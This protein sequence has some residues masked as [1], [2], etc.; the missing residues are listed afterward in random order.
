MHFVLSV[1][2]PALPS[3]TSTHR[4]VIQ[5]V[6]DVIMGLN[7]WVVMDQDYPK[8]SVLG[9]AHATAPA[10]SALP[11]MVRCHVL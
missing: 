3:F 4:Y 5:L 11:D 6:A 7:F 10:S 8:A 1:S 9:E 2:L